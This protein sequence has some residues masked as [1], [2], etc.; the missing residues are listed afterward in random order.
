[1]TS[2]TQREAPRLPA[3]TL[4][5]PTSLGFDA[6]V[7]RLER[8]ITDHGLMVIAKPSASRN[9]AA[10]G[11]AIPGNAMFLAFNN[12]YAQRMLAA[13]PEAGFEAPMRF[14][15]TE[16]ADHT[17]SVIYRRASALWDPY[18]A[19]ALLEL[20]VELDALFAEIVKSATA[21]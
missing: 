5:T 8:A 1:V 9:A 17:A 2:P 3:G 10:R 4:V 19:P 18:G 14:Y 12:D 15:V 13:S 6:L 16:H 7:S 20:G 11:V 21:D